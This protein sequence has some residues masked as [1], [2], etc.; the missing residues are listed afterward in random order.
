M[1]ILHWLYNQPLWIAAMIIMT[2]VI[3]VSVSG[4]LFLHARIPAHWSDSKDAIG[5][6][7]SAV[8]VIYAVLL[9][10]IA[11]AAWDDYTDLADKVAEEA[12]LTNNLFRDAEGLPEVTRLALQ[13][14]YRQYVGDVACREWPLLQQG[15]LDASHTPTHDTVLN[16]MHTVSA[17]KPSD[18]GEA[19]VHRETLSVVNHLLSLRRARLMSAD[20]HLL[21]ILWLVL[22][23][24][25]LATM[26]LSWC[27]HV[28]DRRLHVLLNGIYSSVVGLMMFCI[29]SLDHPFWGEISVDAE[30]F[31]F[32]GHS[33]DRLNRDLG[34][35]DCITNSPD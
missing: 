26:A 9:G 22:L 13:K 33:L 3:G 15:T 1:G 24:G 17:F 25:G 8:G 12:S 18:L 29:F 16:I 30:P 28:S 19:N 6:C 7:A 20:T 2:P 10:M 34:I 27:V 5:A 32:V 14:H 4:A 23:A 21:P 11:V 31:H 35:T